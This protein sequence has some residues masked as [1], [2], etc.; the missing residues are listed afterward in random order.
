MKHLVSYLVLLNSMFPAILTERV[1]Y[2]KKKPLSRINHEGSPTAIYWGDATGRY[3]GS[4][5]TLLPG[6]DGQGVIVDIDVFGS[7]RALTGNAEINIKRYR[8]ALG[9]QR[10]QKR[11]VVSMAGFE[12]VM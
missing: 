10:A 7:G 5:K 9:R 12:T 11:G 4:R 8:G 2:C 6:V 3:D 1:H